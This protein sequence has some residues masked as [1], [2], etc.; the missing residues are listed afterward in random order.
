MWLIQVPVFSC[1]KCKMA[2]VVDGPMAVLDSFRRPFVPKPC[3]GN[4][5]LE[6]RPPLILA[7]ERN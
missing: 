1:T 3:T 7:S 5:I 6:G 2:A 4:P